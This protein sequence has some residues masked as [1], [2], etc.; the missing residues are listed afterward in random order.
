M[1]PVGASARRNVRTDP[2][3]AVHSDSI[4]LSRYKGEFYVTPI[5]RRYPN[6]CRMLAVWGQS[7]QGIPGEAAFST[8]SLN[9]FAA[10]KA[11]FV[12]SA[13]LPM[14][15]RPARIKRSER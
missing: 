14:E 6:F 1:W 8:I 15:G 7:M 13:V 10:L 11:M 12:A 2:H 4:G 3:V 5:A 9:A